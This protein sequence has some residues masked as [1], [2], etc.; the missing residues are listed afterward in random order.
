M[1][2]KI[3]FIIFILTV[4]LV[5]PTSVV[6]G[7]VT[8]NKVKTAVGNPAPLPGDGTSSSSPL[9]QAGMDLLMAYKT[10]APGSGSTVNNPGIKGCLMDYLR[11]DYSQSIGNFDVRY[12]GAV[13]D[14]CVECVGFVALSLALT[15][16]GSAP[17]YGGNASYFATLD[18]I[19]A[20]TFVY[21]RIKP[22]EAPEPGDI[23]A[24]VAGTFGHILIVKSVPQPV[25]FIAVESNWN[26]SCAVSDQF[27][28]RSRDYVFFR[29]VQ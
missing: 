5:N 9:L 11:K 3:V 25:E 16:G 27:S 13:T 14:R 15:G 24:S 28:H 12:G 6:L 26:Y 2:K 4:V 21:Q 1:F 8:S 18:N 20:G 19:T 23:G 7:K 29:L 10:C 17:L 22:G